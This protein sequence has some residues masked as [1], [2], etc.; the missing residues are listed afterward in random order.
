VTWDGRSLPYDLPLVL[1]VVA[2]FVGAGFLSPRGLPVILGSFG[3]A[4]HLGSVGR[5]A[6]SPSGALVRGGSPSVRPTPALD[7]FLA[8]VRIVVG[9]STRLARTAPG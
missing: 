8:L 6:L 1:R 4:E 2:F 7:L 5:L 3:V 9:H